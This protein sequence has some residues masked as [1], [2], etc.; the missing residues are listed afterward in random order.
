M[1]IVISKIML[2]KSTTILFCTNDE[3]CMKY[4]CASLL[5]D[6]RYRVIVYIIQ[7]ITVFVLLL[8]NYLLLK[9]I[10]TMKNIG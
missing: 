3:K 6:Q 7:T 2:N 10:S 9:S 5:H 4:M 1:Q 8:A